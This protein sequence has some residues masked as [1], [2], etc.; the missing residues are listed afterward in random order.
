MRL[1]LHAVRKL[2][3]QKT[4]KN[5]ID[6][7]VKGRRKGEISRGSPTTLYRVSRKEESTCTV[8]KRRNQQDF[9]WV[10]IG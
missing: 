1:L 4:E 9:D 8:E 7:Y 3:Q 6:R 5:M 10:G 2:E